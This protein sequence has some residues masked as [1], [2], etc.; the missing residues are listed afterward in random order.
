MKE[1]YYLL[2]LV[3]VAIGSSI[4][5]MYLPRLKR[6]LKRVFKR[7]KLTLTQRVELLEKRVKLHENKDKT[8]LDKFDEMEALF[9]RRENDRKSKVRKQVR[10][11]LEELQK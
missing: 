8:Y 10:A 1:I 11:Y 2:M 3:L 9:D 6:V 7:N 5:T 4:T